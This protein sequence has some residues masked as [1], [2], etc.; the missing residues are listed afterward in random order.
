MSRRGKNTCDIH[1]VIIRLLSLRIRLLILIYTLENKTYD[2]KV[3]GWL[4]VD[5]SSVNGSGK[6]VRASASNVWEGGG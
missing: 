4:C 6:V 2:R 1:D 5:S 3:N